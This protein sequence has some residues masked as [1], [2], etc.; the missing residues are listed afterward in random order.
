MYIKINWME[1]LKLNHINT[2]ESSIS[3]LG[4]RNLS[5][6]SVFIP[7]TP[8]TDTFFFLNT[9]SVWAELL[10]QG[11]FP[12]AVWVQW[13][14]THDSGYNFHL[15]SHIERQRQV[16]EEY[17]VLAPLFDVCTLNCQGALAVWN[18]VFSD[19][20]DYFF[21]SVQLFK[22]WNDVFKT[23]HFFPGTLG[24]CEVVFR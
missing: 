2:P 10:V 1:G 3:V 23:T 24:I 9:L 11:H 20:P 14:S 12:A 13:R 15:E 6:V 7:K 16:F 22:A 17:F 18:C 19:V 8:I 21:F 4:T 5:Y